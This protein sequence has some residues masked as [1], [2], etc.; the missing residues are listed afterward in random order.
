MVFRKIQNQA[1]HLSKPVLL[2]ETGSSI[3]IR[4]ILAVFGLLLLLFISWSILAELDEV[5]VAQGEVIPSSQVRKIQHPLG[6]VI[7]RIAI[8]EGQFIEENQTVIWLK[9]SDHEAQLEVKMIQAKS[10]DAQRERLQFYVNQINKNLKAFDFR[11]IRLTTYH[12]KI[13]DSLKDFEKIQGDILTSQIEQLKNNLGVLVG[14][15]ENLIE[16]KSSLE[17]ELAAREILVFKREESKVSLLNLRRQYKSVSNELSQIPLQCY[18]LFVDNQKNALSELAKID[19]ERAQ[20]NKLIASN[21][22]NL[23]R[24]RIKVPV[25]GIVHNL[26]ARTSGEVIAPGKTIFEIVPRE[27]EM[28]AEVHLQPKDIGHVAVNQKAILIFTAYDISSYGSLDGIITKISPTT[29]L[30]SKGD[31]YY[32]TTIK[33]TK[34]YLGND[35]HQNLVLPGMTL[36][37]DIKTGS[38]TVFQYLLRPIFKS[39]QQ[40]LRER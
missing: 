3:I 23:G 27:K 9:S 38:K 14:L 25:S 29:F 15:E 1:K 37:A 33:L 12:G 7:D 6:G 8:E 39:G 20:I 10:L 30:D 2:E 18:K 35:P 26:S 34:G 36:E 24:S 4:L 32:K 28:K 22:E 13:L 5:A 31:P 40:A 11:K 19:N 17:R 21:K 16:Q